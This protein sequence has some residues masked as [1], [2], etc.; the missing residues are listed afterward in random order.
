MGYKSDLVQHWHLS[1]LSKVS[2]QAMDMDESSCA[3]PRNP[4]LFS[5]RL[6]LWPVGRCKPQCLGDQK[7]RANPRRRRRKRLGPKPSQSTFMSRSPRSQPSHRSHP[8]QLKSTV[9]RASGAQ[10]QVVLWSGSSL[11]IWRRWTVRPFHRPQL[12][13]MRAAVAWSSRVL[14][15]SNGRNWLTLLQRPLRQCTFNT[16]VVLDGCLMPN[17]SKYSV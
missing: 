17:T 10:M 15:P 16:L 11:T 14:S 1:N 13:M 5:K 9:T 2:N 7:Q 8:F 4:L 3:W 6:L 12:S